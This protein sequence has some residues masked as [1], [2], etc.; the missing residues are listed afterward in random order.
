MQTSYWQL[1]QSIGWAILDNVVVGISH[2]A[3][4]GYE[5]RTCR[6]L[7]DFHQWF[8]WKMHT[9]Q[10]LFG[11]NQECLQ[12]NWLIMLFLPWDR[13][14]NAE[15]CQQFWFHPNQKGP[16]LHTGENFLQLFVLCYWYF[17]ISKWP[18]LKNLCPY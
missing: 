6:V 18:V 16:L 8:H 2:I 12:G 7:E 10:A 1:Q 14:A 4:E 3:R 17:Y 9:P 11:E 13:V 15:S 5:N